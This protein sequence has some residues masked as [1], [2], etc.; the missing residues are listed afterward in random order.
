MK[1]NAILSLIVLLSSSF[2]TTAQLPPQTVVFK[3]RKADVVKPAHIIS[4]PAVKNEEEQVFFVVEESATFQ[5]GD[6]NSFRDWVFKNTIYPATA[7]QAGITGK[8]IVQ[9]CI[10]SKGDVTDV[11]VIRSVSP[12][13]DKEAIRVIS[14]SPKWSPGKQGGKAI[15][16]LFTMPVVF[17]LQ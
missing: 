4:R 7:V 8:V 5:G 15:K 16:Q 9:F 6:L 3:V 10:D 1:L 17:N 14:S 2:I 13:I 12:E 11:K